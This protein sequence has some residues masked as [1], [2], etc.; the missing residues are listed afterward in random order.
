MKSQI[1]S[2]SF[3]TS[4][5]LR[6]GSGSS[7]DSIDDILACLGKRILMISDNVL[8]NLGLYEPMKDR[9]LSYGVTLLVF[10]AVEQDPSLNTLIKSVNTGLEFAPTGVLGIGGGSS[11]DVAKL[12]ALFLKSD[13]KIKDV[14]GVGNVK[15]PRLPLCLIPTTAGTGSEVTPVSI[16]T[17]ED[18]EKR[19]V[20]SSIILPDLAI[21]DPFLTV[22]LPA[23]ITAATGIDAIVHSIEAFSSKH[24]NNNH[25][26]R[27]LAT[28][29]LRLLGRSIKTAVSEGSNI[30]ARG[31][32]LLG[33]MMAGMAFA[34][35]PVAAVH[36]LAYPIGGSFHIPHGLSNSLVLPEVLRFNALNKQA[37]D[38]YSALAPI[39]FPELEKVRGSEALATC[40][41]DSLRQLSEDLGLP[42]RLRDVQ[43][44]KSSLKKMASDAMRQKRL[45]VNNPRKIIE[46]DIFKIYSVVW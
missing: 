5:G 27:I 18:D 11:M 8:T 7:I 42:V 13:D 46:E 43:I 24:A 3:N 32:M 33:S 29:S 30:S 15:G 45:L 25:L 22:G 1:S 6:F 41:S 12:T 23:N 38:D 40:F 21:L 31:D 26:S 36:A 20:V 39:V 10:D 9:L 2:F 44:P 35:S 37:S 19:G 28:E 14:W 16:I 4:Q 34:N 17:L